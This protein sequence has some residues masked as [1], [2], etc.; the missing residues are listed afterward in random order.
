MSKIRIDTA[1]LNKV[2]SQ[3]F[4]AT[5]ER[6]DHALDEAITDDLYEY[7]R[8]TKRRSGEI[9]G[10]PRNIVDLGNLKDSKVVAR[11]SSSEVVEFSWQEPYSMAVHEGHTTKSGT[12]VPPRRWTEKGVEICDPAKVFGQELERRL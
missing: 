11:S 3:A 2:I 1:K 6:L 4:D 10:S 5:V 12:E 9:A 7:P 8:T